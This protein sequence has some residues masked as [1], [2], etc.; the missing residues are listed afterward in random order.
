MSFPLVGNGNINNTL[1]NALELH[2]LPHAVLIDGDIGTGRHT[3]AYFL[4][5]AMVCSDDKIPC[6]NC[7]NCHL[8]VTNNHPDIRIIAP[9]EGKK[10][11]S[12]KQIR[13]LKINAYIK[14][15]QA[16]SKVFVIDY[17]DTLNAESQNALLKVLE[18][19][20]HNTFFI[21]VAESKASLLE[22][23]ISR[24]VVLSLN[25]P[26]FDQALIYLEENTDFAK[27]DIEVA[28]SN[29]KNNIG[30]ALKL[31]RGSE[32]NSTLTAAKD[33][34]QFAL[35]GDQWNMLCITA[36]FEKKRNEAEHFL[37][38]LKLSVAEEIKNNPKGIRAAALLKFY[39]KLY[40]FEESLVTNINLS[41][42]FSDLV[43]EA[44]ECI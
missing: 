22:T 42:L 13:Q 41:L 40:L 12:V 25:V 3:L 35:N 21:L 5:K 43:A 19:P 37:K 10:N 34:L 36:G 6:G 8:A 28:L 15:H 32:N 30:K 44:K 9:E 27:C 31:L 17:A 39:N 7:H 11:I 23:V 14:P 20:P 33:F 16:K 4:A 29:A 2:R 1:S 18:E 38:D 24:C 26:Q